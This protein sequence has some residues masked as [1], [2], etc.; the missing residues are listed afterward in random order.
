MQSMKKKNTCYMQRDQRP[1]MVALPSPRP[2]QEVVRVSDSTKHGVSIRICIWMTRTENQL[3]EL[4]CPIPGR[5]VHPEGHKTD[6]SHDFRKEGKE[7]WGVKRCLLPADRTP[8]GSL[9]NSH[10][11][12]QSQITVAFSKELGNFYLSLLPDPIKLVFSEEECRIVM[13]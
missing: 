10:T 5:G 12:F 11:D 1:Y 2:H 4:G 3:K 8:Q 6:T 9:E 7:V 13:G